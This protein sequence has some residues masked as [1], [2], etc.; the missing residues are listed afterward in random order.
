[1]GNKISNMQIKYSSFVKNIL[2]NNY[3]KFRNDVMNTMSADANTIDEALAKVCF[4]LLEMR[5]EMMLSNMSTNDCIELVHVICK[6]YFYIY[7]MFMFI[8]IFL[9]EFFSIFILCK[10]LHWFVQLQINA[11]LLT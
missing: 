7:V 8:I 10:Y 3:N 1:M 4:E 2:T 11:Y 5:D 9:F 6:I